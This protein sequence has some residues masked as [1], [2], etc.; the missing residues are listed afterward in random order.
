MAQSVLSVRMDSDTK[1]A[2]AA[3]CEEVGMS[4]STAINLFA[5][6]TLRERRIP[7]EISTEPAR[8]HAAARPSQRILSRDEITAAV[9]QAAARLPG[10]SSVVLFGSYARGEARPDSDIDLRITY[11]EEAVTL[12][13]LSEFLQDVQDVTG[14]S[15]DVVSRHDLGN[16][17]FAQSIERDGVTIYERP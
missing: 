2:F 6:Q 16:D 15:V 17:D 9:T 4:V 12:F 7:F 11:D 10:I 1:A 13:G 14:K 5:R 3:F 8:A